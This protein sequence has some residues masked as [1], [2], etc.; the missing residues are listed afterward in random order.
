MENDFGTIIK[1][2]AGHDKNEYFVLINSDDKF[3]YI[4]DGK[5]RTLERPKKK[6]R[7]HVQF[8]RTKAFDNNGDYGTQLPITNELINKKLR[9]FTNNKI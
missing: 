1:S 7:K 8:T 9:E 3:V 5:S 2:L 4:A 6:N